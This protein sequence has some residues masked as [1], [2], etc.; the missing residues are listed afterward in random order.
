MT[1]SELVPRGKGE[2]QPGE[3]GEKY[4]KPYANKESERSRL[5]FVQHELN[6]KI[7]FQNA[8]LKKFSDENFYWI[9]EGNYSNFDFC[10][11]NFEFKR[12]PSESEVRA[13]WRSY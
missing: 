11:L 4:L 7:K 12:V 1:D 3:G 5:T 8:K 9:A 13:S 2:K 6:L 10:I